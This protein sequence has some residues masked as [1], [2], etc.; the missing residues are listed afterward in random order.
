MLKGHKEIVDN[1]VATLVTSATTVEEYTD[2]L[3]VVQGQAFDKRNFNEVYTSKALQHMMEDLYKGFRKPIH[4]F[5]HDDEAQRD[6]F[7]AEWAID[8]LENSVQ[9]R[10]KQADMLFEDKYRRENA[11]KQANN[12][13]EAAAEA[14]G[15]EYTG[16]REKTL[17]EMHGLEESDP[18]DRRTEEELEYDREMKKMMNDAKAAGTMS[19]DSFAPTPASSNAN[20]DKMTPGEAPDANGKLTITDSDGIVNADGSLNI[21]R[22]TATKTG[23]PV[24]ENLK[25]A[26]EEAA[27]KLKEEKLA[28]RARFSPEDFAAVLAGDGSSD[29]NNI[30]GDKD[31]R[32]G[33][34]PVDRVGLSP[35]AEDARAKQRTAEEEAM[36]QTRR[37]NDFKHKQEAEKGVFRGSDLFGEDDVEWEDL[38]P[39]LQTSL[40]DNGFRASTVSV[41]DYPFNSQIAGKSIIPFDTFGSVVSDPGRES[42]AVIDTVN[43]T[44]HGSIN[45][46]ATAAL[47]V[48]RIDESKDGWVIYQRTGGRLGNTVVTSV[49]KVR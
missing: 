38:D 18:W 10:D 30:R 6:A 17:S 49:V 24:D 8:V 45:M 43:L 29:A 1:R 2:F 31:I 23:G 27:D 40:Q 44:Q 46:G 28:G 16:P 21:S 12:A 3:K 34:K 4:V 33:A 36:E 5:Y 35:D 22:I 26:K 13:A 14:A 48:S 37:E 25:K 41:K 15:T 7:V 20:P 39:A 42:T 32:S 9:S 11:E 19:D 47:V